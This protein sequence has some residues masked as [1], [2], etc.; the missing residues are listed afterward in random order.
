[1]GSNG[2]GGWRRWA[3]REEEL[4]GRENC[5]A[6]ASNPNIERRAV[7]AR[8]Q[9]TARRTAASKEQERERARA[10]TQGGG[11]AAAAWGIRAGSSAAFATQARRPEGAGAEGTEAEGRERRL[12]KRLE[13]EVVR[14]GLRPDTV[15]H[16]STE[17]V[18]QKVTRLAE[19]AGVKIDGL[20]KLGKR[21]QVRDHTNRVELAQMRLQRWTRG[22]CG[23]AEVIGGCV[24]F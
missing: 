18:Q 20:E 13:G 21:Y 7:I 22:G 4:G 1:M 11:G 8:Q 17:D 10:I 2:A 9:E 14:G 16:D 5:T 19:R 15:S 23:V 6:N 24:D 3:D 12:E